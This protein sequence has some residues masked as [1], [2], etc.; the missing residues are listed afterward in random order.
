[1]ATPRKPSLPA[2]GGGSIGVAQGVRRRD[3]LRAFSGRPR[4]SRGG[5]IARP[6]CSPERGDCAD[7][8]RKPGPTRSRSRSLTLSPTPG[9]VTI[10]EAIMSAM[11]DDCVFE[12]SAGVGVGA[13][14]TTVNARPERGRGGIRAIP[15]R[16]H[17]AGRD[18]S[19]PGTGRDRLRCFPAPGTTAFGSSPGCDVFTFK[20]GE[21]A[22]KNS[23][24][25]QRSG[26]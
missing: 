8:A 2:G 15:G 6:H 9:T 1:M 24:R 10:V 20:D 11:T 4:R 19:S 17:G 23:Y 25:K 16:R 22:V 5:R 7:A 26:Y 3:R 12:A 21:I 14:S 18:T 13:P